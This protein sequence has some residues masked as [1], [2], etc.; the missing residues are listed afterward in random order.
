MASEEDMFADLLMLVIPKAAQEDARWKFDVQK[1]SRLLTAYRLRYENYTAKV[2]DC[3]CLQFCRDATNPF[4]YS[5]IPTFTSGGREMDWWYLPTASGKN[6]LTS[7]QEVQKLLDHLDKN[8]D[9][10]YRYKEKVRTEREAGPEVHPCNPR[11]PQGV[12]Q[13]PQKAPPSSKKKAGAMKAAKASISGSLASSSHGKRFREDGP[14]AV[15][16]EPTKRK[17]TS[18]SVEI[19][20]SEGETETHPVVPVEASGTSKSPFRKVGR[21]SKEDK[22]REELD[23]VALASVEVFLSDAPSLPVHPHSGGTIFSSQ[24]WTTSA[25]NRQKLNCTKE[26]YVDTGA[27]NS[28]PDLRKSPLE[29]RFDDSV[30]YSW[31]LLEYLLGGSEAMYRSFVYSASDTSPIG[32][33]DLLEHIRKLTDGILEHIERAFAVDRTEDTQD[34]LEEIVRL[35]MNSA[36]RPK[37]LVGHKSVSRRLSHTFARDHLRKNS[38]PGADKVQVAY[39][40]DLYLEREKLREI[41]QRH[42]EEYVKIHDQ[43]RDDRRWFR[44][45][46]E[47]IIE[48]MG[49]MDV[50]V[51][52]LKTAGG[53]LS[54]LGDNVIEAAYERTKKT[55]GLHDCFK[56]KAFRKGVGECQAWHKKPTESNLGLM[57]SVLF[58]FQTIVTG[59]SSVP[60]APSEVLPAE[61]GAN[62]WIT[63]ASHRTRLSPR[64]SVY[65]DT[66]RLAEYQRYLGPE[67]T[68]KNKDWSLYTWTLIQHAVGGEKVLLKKLLELGKANEPLL[69]ALDTELKDAV[70]DHVEKLFKLPEIIK[71]DSLRFASTIRK[72]LLERTR[73]FLVRQVEAYEK[74]KARWHFPEL[75]DRPK[76]EELTKL[77]QQ[78]YWRKPAPDRTQLRP[79]HDVYIR[80]KILESIAQYFGPQSKQSSIKKYSMAL[81][82]HMLGGLE[83]AFSLWQSGRFANGL[84][85]VFVLDD[86]I[87]VCLHADSVFHLVVSIN[88]AACH[89]AV[90]EQMAVL[91]RTT[92]IHDARMANGSHP[93]RPRSLLEKAL[94]VP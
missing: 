56:L 20:S 87:A 12:S 84:T 21:P 9:E 61:P 79:G 90:S 43:V 5:L 71:Q 6:V 31:T 75:D 74:G 24:Y 50:F 30:K 15:P 51:D 57:A 25:D 63:P 60:P 69:E 29:S 80:T 16:I 7:A 83:T 11:E 89:F 81:L 8:Y 17:K 45:G 2:S 82:M 35:K 28:V 32:R 37:V 67:S 58:P 38:F 49:G 44:Y 26:I 19:P 54:L 42:K 94:N 1:Q 10:R 13:S 78:E 22:M 48:L 53:L 18:K 47:I 27:L 46:C 14:S 76:P 88:P 52:G 39:G 70:F 68:R 85:S 77:E 93:R 62:Y 64:F 73:G 3:V 23:S 33:K 92:D 40:F 34:K 91:R 55:F 65:M 4:G 72:K 36:C 86:L 66:V 41:D 59:F